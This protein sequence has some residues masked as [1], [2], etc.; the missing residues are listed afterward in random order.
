MLNVEHVC[1]PAQQIIIHCLISYIYDGIQLMHQP[2]IKKVTNP[3][4]LSHHR[5]GSRLGVQKRQFL[6]RLYGW[7]YMIL[8]VCRVDLSAILPTLYMDP[9]IKPLDHERKKPDEHPQDRLLK[10]SCEVGPLEGIYMGDGEGSL[11]CTIFQHLLTHIRMG[12]ELVTLPYTDVQPSQ[13]VLGLQTF[14]RISYPVSDSMYTP[15][16][17]LSMWVMWHL[18]N[19]TTVSVPGREGIRS[20]ACSMMGVH[21]AL[22]LPQ[23]KT[24]WP[25]QTN[26]YHRSISLR[27][28]RQGQVCFISLLTLLHKIHRRNQHTFYKPMEKS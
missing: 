15:L 10:T 25:C 19:L 8:S 22:N 23:D 20:F 3:F 9:L 7:K 14:V 2:A 17:C 16:L 18:V 21:T 11:R 27:F 4:R 1:Y 12:L 5:V 26:T 13:P 24:L 6:S 28:L